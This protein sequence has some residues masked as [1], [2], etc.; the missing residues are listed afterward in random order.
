MAIEHKDIAAIRED[1]SKGSLSENDTL[2][3]PFEQF[4]LWFNQALDSHVLEPNAMVLGTINEAGYPS[5]RVVL[6]K[7]LKA[8]GLSFFT[9]YTSQKGQDIARQSKVSLLFFWG[10]LQ[11]QVR[12]EGEVS[13]LPAEDS[14]EYFASRPKGSQIGAWSSPQSQ[15]IANREVLESNVLNKEQEYKD[16]ENIPRP[17]FWGGYLVKPVRFEFWQGRSSR[18][19]DRI[20]YRKEHNVWTK[21]RLAP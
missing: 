17:E 15:I 8:D 4:Q 6:L 5:T 16:L 14:D 9:N 1:Y 11:R 7:D 21:N 18:L 13:F 2:Q 10:E 20:V 19:H 12:I 3:N